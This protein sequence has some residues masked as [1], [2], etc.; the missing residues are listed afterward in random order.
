MRV[1][2]PRTQQF[3]ICPYFRA[4]RDVT[5]AQ[6][7]HILGTGLIQDVDAAAGAP[8]PRSC[9]RLGELQ[10]QGGQVRQD[11]VGLDYWIWRG[12]TSRPGSSLNDISVVYLVVR[13]LLGCLMLLTQ[14]QVSKGCRALGAPAPER[15]AL[16]PDQP[17]PLSAGRC[18]GREVNGRFYQGIHTP[19]RR[20]CCIS[21]TR[22]RPEPPGYD[23][24]TREPAG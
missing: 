1:Q 13:C 24:G 16:P 19:G 17:G 9:G 12:R 21:Q 5:R 4:C 20:P 18:S 6:T 7:D 22:S 3:P 15:G 14:R 11:P 23:R 10:V 2:V 8:S